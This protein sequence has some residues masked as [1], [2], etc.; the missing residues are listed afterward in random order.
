ME[1]EEKKSLN[2]KRIVNDFYSALNE[3][4]LDT[5]AGKFADQIDWYIPG[6]QSLAPWLGI[7]TQRYEVKDFFELL[8]QNIEPVSLD[9]EHIVVEGNFAVATGQF[10]SKMLA[11]GI[12]YSSPF[13]A[14]F[15]IQGDFIVRYRFLED[16]NGLVKALKGK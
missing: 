11:T 1:Y 10:V 16:S 5:V 12:E 13:S 14:H 2:T 7:R 3:R 9:I 8:L 4:E 15:T 6:E